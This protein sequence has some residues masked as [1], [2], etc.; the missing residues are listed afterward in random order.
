MSRIPQRTYVKTGKPVPPE[1][2]RA[3]G[4]DITGISCVYADFDCGPG[5]AYPDKSVALAHLDTLPVYPTATI[6]SGGG[7]HTYWMLSELVSV[8]ED[9]HEELRRLQAAWVLL[10][11]AD[12]GAHDLQRVLRVPG[13]LNRKY[14]PPRPV[15]FVEYRPRRCYDLSDLLK[16]AGDHMAGIEAQERLQ[17]EAGSLADGYA[18]SRRSRCDHGGISCAT[19]KTASGIATPCGQSIGCATRGSPVTWPWSAY[20]VRPGK[21]PGCRMRKN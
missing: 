1:R 7:I 18:G 8:G 13:T 11:A 2:M 21:Y 9:N 17:R 3:A 4:G 12:N 10:V 14:D 5:K 15:Q 20:R 16:L 6:D 19:P